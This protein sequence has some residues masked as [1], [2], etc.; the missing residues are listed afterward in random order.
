MENVRKRIDMHLIS[1]DDR[2]QKLINRPTFKHVTQ[3]NENLSAVSLAK[4]TLKF[5]KPLYVGFAVLEI[6]KTLMYDY[7]YNV[8]K[9]HYK[10]SITL[11]YT[12]TGKIFIFLLLLLISL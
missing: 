2:M 7:H 4:N 9:K 3:Y 5:D 8:M 1:N 12:D 6:S 11:M 10:D